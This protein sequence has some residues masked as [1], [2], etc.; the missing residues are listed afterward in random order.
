MALKT[1]AELLHPENMS[2]D[3]RGCSVVG[4]CRQLEELSFRIDRDYRAYSKDLVVRGMHYQPDCSK[5]VRC[6]AGAVVDYV[7]DLREK[8]FGVVDVIPM[9][10]SP[11]APYL[12][13]PPW[14]AHGYATLVAAEIHYLIGGS[15]DP[16]TEVCILWNSI[17]A[18]W[19]FRDPILSDRDARGVPLASFPPLA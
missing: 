8:S 17:D 2:F 9:H 4:L 1:G 16:A 13:V 14:C 19:P 7:V 18:V 12:F 5:L 6:C 3:K 11:A 10:G 15:F